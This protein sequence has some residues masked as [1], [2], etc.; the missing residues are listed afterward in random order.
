MRERLLERLEKLKTEF[1]RGKA[2]LAEVEQEEARL[3]ETMLRIAGAIQVLTEELE[4]GK[5]PSGG[6]A[7]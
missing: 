1:E 2:R 4:L 5:P 6:E 3:R 7:A